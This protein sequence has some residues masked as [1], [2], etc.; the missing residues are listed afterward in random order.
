[1][2]R[3]LRSGDQTLNYCAMRYLVIFVVIVELALVC[4]P[5]QA[6]DNEAGWLLA[7]INSLR[8]RNGLGPLTINAPLTNSATAHSTYLATHNYANPHVEDNGSTPQSRALSAGYPSSN[9]GEN[10]VGGSQANAAWGFNW[11]LNSPVHLYNMLGPWTEVGIGVSSGPMGHWYTTD[12]GEAAGGSSAPANNP[13]VDTAA[14]N[15]PPN[16]VPAAPQK[17]AVPS[18][19]PTRIPTRAPT[20]TPTITLTPSM[21]F[22]Q[23]A[24]FTPTFTPT[25]LPP[26]E[27]AIV[28]DVSPQP[29]DTPIAEGLL[30]A[31]APTSGLRDNS[32]IIAPTGLP[33]SKVDS[34]GGIRSMIPWFIS[35]QA[36]LV[37]GLVV[38]SVMRRKR[39]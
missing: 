25:G 13:S 35:L 16:A 2:A 1:M 38:G 18:G 3:H 31:M 33:P 39:R 24:T 11:W 14:N 26:T 12:F 6:Q 29:S 23:H 37:G 27:T 15:A 28:I 10:V 5:A 19:P 9:V 22:T 17:A 8:A 4:S 20:L 7:Q 34:N 32:A 21:T 30:V 36:L